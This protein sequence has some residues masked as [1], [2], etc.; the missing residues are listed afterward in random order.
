MLFGYFTVN[1]QTRVHI[2][3]DP[4]VVRQPTL[5]A[6]SPSLHSL[7]QMEKRAFAT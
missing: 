5:G 3:F 2:I 7:R 4:T 1:A 6:L